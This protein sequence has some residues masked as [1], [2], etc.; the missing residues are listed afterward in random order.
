MKS[1]VFITDMTKYH[2]ASLR[3][4][5]LRGAMRFGTFKSVDF[6][7]N[8]YTKVPVV[9]RT[10]NVVVEIVFLLFHSKICIFVVK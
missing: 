7:K 6:K 10:S 4:M 2:N 8:W 1:S 9:P 3:S 5:K